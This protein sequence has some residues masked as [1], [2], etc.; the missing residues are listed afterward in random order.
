MMRSLLPI[1]RASVNGTNKNTAMTMIAACQRVSFIRGMSGM[2]II[3][4]GGCEAPDGAF[5]SID[6][7]FKGLTPPAQG[8]RWAATLRHRSAVHE[9]LSTQ[10]VPPLDASRT[11]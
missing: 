7:A 8:V 2:M 10:Q 5:H 4:S 11:E 1:P 6:V 9:E 3:P